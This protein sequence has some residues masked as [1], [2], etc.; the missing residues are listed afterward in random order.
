MLRKLKGLLTRK[1]KQVKYRNC[2]TGKYC[3]K[4]YAEANPDTTVAERAR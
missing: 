3:S 1:P 4:A 2:I